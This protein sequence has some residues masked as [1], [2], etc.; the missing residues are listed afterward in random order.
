MAPQQAFPALFFALPVQIQL[1]LA[2]AQ[3][4]AALPRCSTD[5]PFWP[6][7]FLPEER[8]GPRGALS[9]AIWHS[10]HFPIDWI[11]RGCLGLLSI[12]S[13]LLGVVVGAWVLSLSP[14]AQPSPQ[15]HDIEPSTII[16]STACSLLRSIISASRCAAQ[17]P[18]GLWHAE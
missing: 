3:E 5:V 17:Q 7:G 16:T 11:R 13:V 8:V 12:C 2:Q 4:G 15:S 6:E 9:V 14:H 18:E 1:G 10:T